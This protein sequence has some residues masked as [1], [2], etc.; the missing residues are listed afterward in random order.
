[1]LLLLPLVLVVNVV[2]KW[3]DFTYIYKYFFL[4]GQSNFLSISLSSGR[5]VFL[6]VITSN[7][8]KFP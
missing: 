1:M 2:K 6:P 5:L 3:L 4:S 7:H 8:L